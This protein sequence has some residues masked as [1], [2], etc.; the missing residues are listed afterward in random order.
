MTRWFRMYDELLDDPKVQKLPAEDFKAWVNLLAL[1]SKNGGILPGIEDIAFALRRSPNDVETLLERLSN[2][3]HNGGANAGLIDKRNGGPNG[4]HYAP[5]GWDKRQYKSDGSTERVKRFRQRSRNGDETLRGTGPEPESDTEQTPQP[6]ADGGLGSG[7]KVVRLALAACTIA[8]VKHGKAAETHVG[9][10]LADGI[11]E[12]TIVETIRSMARN[13]VGKSRSLSRFD[14]P[15]RRAHLEAK[16]RTAQER[17]PPGKPKSEE[18]VEDPIG[19]EERE[20]VRELMAGLSSTLRA[21]L[22]PTPPA[23]GS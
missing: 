18:P 6:P 14:A 16:G 19:P 17:A 12:V 10:W 11:A 20:K 15:I 13:V 9:R 3:P 22:D 7:R 5:H 21:R 1:A 8:G 23:P 2:A 4:Y